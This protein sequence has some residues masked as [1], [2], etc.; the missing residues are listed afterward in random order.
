MF[1]D[2]DRFV[3]MKRVDSLFDHALRR[4]LTVTVSMVTRPLNR[5]L[6]DNN[7]N[8][9]LYIGISL[10]FLQHNAMIFF[11]PSLLLIWH[12]I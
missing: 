2:D 9:G 4:T 1:R 7:V 5:L 12:I 10:S 11:S 3:M 6:L 8:I